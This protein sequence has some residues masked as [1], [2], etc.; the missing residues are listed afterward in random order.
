MPNSNLPPSNRRSNDPFDRLHPGDGFRI[1]RVTVGSNVSLHIGCYQQGELT[2]LFASAPEDATVELLEVKDADAAA[3][4]GVTR[5][6]LVLDAICR[7]LTTGGDW[8]DLTAV[9]DRMR[10]VA[11]GGIV[12]PGYD[13]IDSYA[14]TDGDYEHVFVRT[15]TD[16]AVLWVEDTFIDH[17][18]LD[19][20]RSEQESDFDGDEGDAGEDDQPDLLDPADPI[21]EG[22]A[23]SGPADD[24]ESSAGP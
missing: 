3:L 21:D 20:I 14:N 17:K 15:G 5:L 22:S 19:Q 24:E 13:L 23:E 2:N 8:H 11:A 4:G 1:K 7:Y 9:M 10:A 6:E 16:K 18:T 12:Y